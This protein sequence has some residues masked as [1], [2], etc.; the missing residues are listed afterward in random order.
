MMAVGRVRSRPGNIGNIGN[1]VRKRTLRNLALLIGPLNFLC[2]FPNT[3]RRHFGR[4]HDAAATKAICSPAHVV[5]PSV[6]PVARC[7]ELRLVVL[8]NVFGY[9]R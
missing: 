4:F 5:L 8:P 2:E 6:E 7:L 1:L 3:N 9:T